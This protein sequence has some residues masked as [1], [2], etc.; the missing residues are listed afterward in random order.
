[1]ES[2][3]SH[4]R[5]GRAAPPPPPP[6]RRRAMVNSASDD[7]HGTT[8]LG[9]SQGT[10]LDSNI[11][12]GSS[13]RRNN[14]HLTLPVGAHTRSRSVSRDVD[15]NEELQGPST[16]SNHWNSGNSPNLV[17]QQSQLQP[18]LTPLDIEFGRL[19]FQSADSKEAF[20]PTQHQAQYSKSQEVLNIMASHGLSSQK[21]KLRKVLSLGQSG[22]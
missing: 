16:I 4:P 21:P 14:N 2:N 3:A 13:T 7:S 18:G 15:V 12:G 6:P 17:G 20:S 9:T 1:M 11:D 22:L 19:R 5:S 8:R 10:M